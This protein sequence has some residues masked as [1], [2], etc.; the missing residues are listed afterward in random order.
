MNEPDIIF[1]DE[2]TGSLDS[3]SPQKSCPCFWRLIEKGKQS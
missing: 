3:K 2:P 1:G